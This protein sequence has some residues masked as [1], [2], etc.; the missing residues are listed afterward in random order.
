ML[1]LRD[2]IP[3]V[4]LV[5]FPLLI[6]TYWVLYPAYGLLDPDAVVR[7]INGHR[8]VTT[9]ANACALLGTILAVPATFGMMRILA[10]RSPKLAL[11]GGS[12]SVLGWISLVGALIP[13]V[14]AIQMVDGGE[15]TP[16]LVD[17]FRR[18]SLSPTMIALNAAVVL[19]LIGGILL[20]VALLRTRIVPR[21]ASIVAIVAP[22]IHLSANLSGR[23]VL[24]A[25]TWVALAAAYACVARVIL[26]P[27]TAEAE[28]PTPGLRT[29]PT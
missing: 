18:F 11:I 14:L 21:W 19:H 8:S 28:T 13:D 7:A 25:L 12:L 27:A 6:L 23:L 9:F 2:S 22:P 29:A 26:Q 15:L 20:G 3:A 24:D 1:R 17:L 5:L 4:S 10:D 16:A